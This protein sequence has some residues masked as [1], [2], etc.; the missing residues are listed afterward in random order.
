[1]GHVSESFTRLAL[2]HP[3]VH[4]TLRHNQRVVYDLPP[5]Q[6]WRERIGRFFGQEL[7]QALIGVESSDGAVRL[8]GYVA[9]P[10]QSRSH[11]RMQ[12]LFLNGRHIRDRALQHALQEAYRGLLLTGRYPICFLWFQMPPELVDV[13]VH[14]TKLEVRFQDGGRLYSQLLGTLRTKFLTTDLNTRL[15]T[16]PESESAQAHD[17]ARTAQLRQELVDWAKGQMAQWSVEG[18]G[19]LS[20][21]STA[22]AV[23]SPPRRPLE[24]NVLDRPWPDAEGEMIPPAPAIQ[25]VPESRAAGLVPAGMNPAARIEPRSTAALQVHN[26]YLIAETEEGMVVIDQHALHERILYEQLRTKVL[27]GSLESQSLLVPEPVDLAAAEVAA[28]LEHRGLLARLGVQIEPFGGDTI[29]VR[30]YPAMLAN[31][32]PQEMLRGLVDQNRLGGQGAGATRPA[33]RASAYDLLQ[34]GHQGGR[35]ARR[36]GDCR[37]A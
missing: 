33:G 23:A 29:L 14:P 5:A 8:S 36:R 20:E 22:T 6:G 34:G 19:E 9:H 7:E 12:Y 16:R 35:P 24:I 17:P 27:A 15:T 18:D 28:V 26:R 37:A 31:I 21:P 4:F 3:D 25:P 32:R 30:S 11:P 1:M 13:N 2:A 10:S